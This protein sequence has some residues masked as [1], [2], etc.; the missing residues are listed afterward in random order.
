MKMTIAIHNR[1]NSF[2]DRWI[3]Y[4]ERSSIMYKIV[5]CY[6]DDIVYQVQNCRGL[7]WHFHH[8]S[9]KDCLFANKLLFALQGMK[10]FKV[11]PDFNTSWHFDDKIG[12]K[13]LLET[14]GAQMVRS[15]V[16]YSKKEA[17]CWA[18]TTTYPKVFKLRG[19]AGSVNVRLV[20]SYAEAMRLIDRSFGSGFKHDSNLNVGE[21]WKK[22]S[23]GNLPFS[24]VL[25][26]VK[27][28]LFQSDFSKINGR[29]R[30]YAYFQE[31]V[32]ENSYDVRVIVIGNKAMAIKRMV[33][34]NDFRASGS[35]NI[36][37]EKCNFTDAIID[38]AFNVSEKLQTQCVAFD[39]VF[40][41]GTPL[42][43]EIS[44]GFSPAG[45]GACPGYW[46]RQLNWYEGSFDP[47]SWMVD[48]VVV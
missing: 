44:Y 48:M 45:Y 27:R 16:F 3:D 30:G 33:R 15:Y 10:N 35:G 2:S 46:D 43:V 36:I 19:G 29:E 26:G 5:N 40:K 41:E 9:S 20:K 47:Y 17:E 32:A 11:F 25:G 14:V 7:M 4:C 1:R 12:Q 34:E 8:A 37:Y 23:K 13:Y 18:K 24:S 6:D 31:F 21:I 22:Y 42:I 38:L 39:F 28:I